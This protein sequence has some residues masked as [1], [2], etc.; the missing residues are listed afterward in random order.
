MASAFSA[1]GGKSASVISLRNALSGQKINYGTGPH[2]FNKPGRVTGELA[3]G[4]LALLTNTI[5]TASA[6][7]FKGKILFIEDVGEYYYSVDRMMIQLERSGA[8]KKIKGLLVGGFTEMKDTVR[9]FGKNAEE[10][11]RDIITPYRIPVAFGFPVSHGKDNL[12][13][14]TGI[15]YTFSVTKKSVSLKEV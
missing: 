4:N 14:K 1:E 3:G 6:C 10:I 9:P 13:L 11:I 5:G 8:L 15:K 2:S 7:P 12:A